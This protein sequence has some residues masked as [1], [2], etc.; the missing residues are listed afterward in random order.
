VQGKTCVDAYKESGHE[1]KGNTAY[2]S[3][4]RMYRNVKVQRYIHYLRNERQQ[5]YSAELDEVIFP[6]LSVSQTPVN[7]PTGTPPAFIAGNQATVKQCGG[8]K[9]LCTTSKIPSIQNT[10]MAEV[11]LKPH[12]AT[13]AA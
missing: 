5:R 4:S 11:N 7:H 6:A 10:P 13:E 3:A 12:T 8:E 1:G 9:P 2:Q